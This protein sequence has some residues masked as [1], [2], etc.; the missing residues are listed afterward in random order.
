MRKQENHLPIQNN[1]WNQSLCICGVVMYVVC[2]HDTIKMWNSHEH[3]WYADKEKVYQRFQVNRA[4][5]GAHES[6]P[7]GFV[8]VVTMCKNLVKPSIFS[9]QLLMNNME[10][11]EKMFYKY[12]HLMPFPSVYFTYTIQRVIQI[13][14]PAKVFIPKMLLFYKWLS[15]FFPCQMV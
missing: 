14:W 2:S 9:Q 10:L 3:T 12:Q 11:L 6:I 4:T 15:L 5:A 7:G 1:C 13:V 8:K